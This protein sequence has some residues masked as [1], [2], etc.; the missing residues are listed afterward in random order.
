MDVF[1]NGDQREKVEVEHPRAHRAAQENVKQIS[2]DYYFPKMTKMANSQSPSQTQ[3]YY[4]RGDEISANHN[5]NLQHLQHL[6]EH[7]YKHNINPQHINTN[8]AP[9]PHNAQHFHTTTKGLPPITTTVHHTPLSS[10]AL[11]GTPLSKHVQVTK[12]VPIPKYHQVQVP[13]NQTVNIEI[14]RPVITTVPRPLPIKIPVTKTVTVPQIQEIKIPIEKIKPFPVQQS[15][16]YLVEK[17][18]PYYVQKQ[19]VTPFY[20]PYPV[21]VPIIKTITH[22]TSAHNSLHLPYGHYNTLR[23]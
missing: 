14:P 3:Y 19:V 11:A 12:F 2:Q 7:Y 13:F 20:Y 21:K 5:N 15:V 10:A 6:Q 16:P 17:R 4:T 8:Y 1:D 9:Q 18:V 22:K 23:G